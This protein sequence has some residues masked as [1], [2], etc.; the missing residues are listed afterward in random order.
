MT[1]PIHLIGEFWCLELPEFGYDPWII[2][3]GTGINWYGADKVFDLQGMAMTYSEGIKLPTGNWQFICISKECSEEV[4]ASIVEQQ[5][6][7]YKDYDKND[8]HWDLPFVEAKKSFDSLLK[9]K[10]LN[11]NNNY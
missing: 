9:S 2:N 5:E 4:A 1:Q 6:S 10:G 7:G 3:G 11:E 8:F